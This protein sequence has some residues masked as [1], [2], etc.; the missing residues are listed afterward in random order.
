MAY[1]GELLKGFQPGQPPVLRFFFFQQPTLTLGRL[2]ARR[3]HIIS[4]VPYPYE[5]RPTGGRAVLHGAHDLCYSIVA[6]TRDPLVGGDLLESYRKISGLLA[7]ALRGLKRDVRLSQEKHSGQGKG[8]C[9]S[10]PSFGELIL[11]GK[12]VAGGA[13]ARE[14]NAFLQQGVILLSVSPEWKNLF[15]DSSESPMAGLNDNPDVPALGRHNL[16]RAIVSVFEKAG[17]IFE[18]PIAA[19]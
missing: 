6:A 12:K 9:F 11:E 16:E 4:G 13:Q 15:R 7:H 1:D 3:L 10:A 19:R 5:I 2:E 8:H 18:K 17:I 14:G